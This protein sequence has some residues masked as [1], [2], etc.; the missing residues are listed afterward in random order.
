[1]ARATSSTGTA[2]GAHLVERGAK[3]HHAVARN[4][5]PHAG[6]SVRGRRPHIMTPAGDIDPRRCRSQAK[7]RPRPR[8]QQQQIPPEEPPGTR[9]VSQGLFVRWKAELS[10]EEPNANSSNVGLAHRQTARLEHAPDTGGGVD[11]PVVLEHARCAGSTRT[12][13]IHVVFDC[14]GE[15]P[16]SGGG[17]ALTGSAS[18][19]DAD[20][21]RPRAG[22]GDTCEKALTAPSRRLDA[23]RAM[24]APP[25]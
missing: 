4:G 15:T 21:R 9:S 13:E 14:Q 19:V 24:R 10:V 6:L 11:A 25:R 18:C 1:M 7:A 5:Q 2:E 17:A 22:S 3:S 20:Q 8:R 16:A 12:H 23:R